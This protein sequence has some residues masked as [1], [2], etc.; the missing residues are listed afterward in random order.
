MKRAGR[1]ETESPEER[2]DLRL[3][4]PYFAAYGDPLTDPD[5]SSYPEGLLQRLSEKGINGIWIHSVLRTLVE[6]DGIF[7]GA[8]DAS[9]RIEGLRRLVERAARYGIGVYLYVNEPRAMPGSFSRPMP[10]EGLF[11]VRPKA[12]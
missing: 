3:I 12:I 7:P 1:T 8:D 10:G 2:F 9:R 6:P 5:L 4:F 11:P